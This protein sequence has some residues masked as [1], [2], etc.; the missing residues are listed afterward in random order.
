MLL[1]ETY[2]KPKHGPNAPKM[3][4]QRYTVNAAVVALQKTWSMQS[5]WSGCG[6]GVEWVGVGGLVVQY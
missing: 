3:G 2:R 1:M 5:T 6:V 4:T